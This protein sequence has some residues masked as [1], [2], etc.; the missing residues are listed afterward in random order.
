MQHK[1]VEVDRQRFESVVGRLIAAAPLPKAAIPRK[2]APKTAVQNP[3][4]SRPKSKA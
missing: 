1:D 4:K 2:R 3:R